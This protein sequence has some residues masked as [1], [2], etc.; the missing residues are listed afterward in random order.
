MEGCVC[1]WGGEWEYVCVF[2]S[3][4]FISFYLHINTNGID[5]KHTDKRMLTLTN[6]HT[7]GGSNWFLTGSVWNSV[8]RYLLTPCGWV[9]GW[10]HALIGFI[11]GPAACLL[12]NQTKAIEWPE[13]ENVQIY[14]I[15]VCLR[16]L[17]V[18]SV[19][20]Q[21]QNVYCHRTSLQGNLSY[22]AH[23]FIQ[24]KYLF[25]SDWGYSGHSHAGL[26]FIPINLRESLMMYKYS[27]SYPCHSV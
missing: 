6:K 5:L 20:I 27:I 24:K 16:I 23:D 2:M 1:V 8:G 17:F 18:C 13:H 14:I 7:C 10:M 4:L 3:V 22:G 12:G 26:L 21:N 25:A 19:N 11:Y 9:G 15:H